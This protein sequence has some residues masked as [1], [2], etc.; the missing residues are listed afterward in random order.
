MTHWVGSAEV[1]WDKALKQKGRVAGQKDSP[2]CACPVV[3]D[4]QKRIWLRAWVDGLLETHHR[5]PPEVKPL[6]RRLKI[7]IPRQA[8]SRTQGE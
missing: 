1:R 3:S 6:L 7:D 2:A 8:I 4:D 5:V